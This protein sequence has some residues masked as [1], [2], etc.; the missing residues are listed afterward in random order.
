MSEEGIVE[1]TTIVDC[2]VLLSLDLGLPC[3][4][5]PFLSGSLPLFVMGIART[6]A[7]SFDSIDSMVTVTVSVH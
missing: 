6:T 3:L 1:G 2:N 7:D 5:L 4:Y